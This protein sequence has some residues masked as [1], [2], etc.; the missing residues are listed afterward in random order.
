MSDSDTAGAERDLGQ[1]VIDLFVSPGEAFTSLLKKS[2]FWLP[3]VAWLLLMFAFQGTWLTKMDTAEFLRSQAELAG[4]PAQLPPDSAMGVVKIVMVVTTLVSM[5]IVLLAVAA[6]YL[7]IFRFMVGAADV[8]F[9]QSL[10]V[11]AWSFLCVGLVSVPLMLGV[12]AMKGEWNM[13]PNLVLQANVAALLDRASVA[14]PL[15]SLADSL[16][17]FS[18]WT[19]F[20]LATGFAAA[21]KRPLATAALG[22]VTPWALYVLIKVGL[23]FLF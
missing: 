22:V 6:I 23:A 7:L 21:S 5:P 18:F 20:L 16:D 12:M 8:K 13:P 2:K 10:T 9:R 15:Y 1:D 11:V 4:K 3:V 17:L 19:L 14:K